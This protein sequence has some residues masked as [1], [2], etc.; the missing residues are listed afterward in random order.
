MWEATEVSGESLHLTYD[1]EAHLDVSLGIPDSSRPGLDQHQMSA[2][3]N[4]QHLLTPCFGSPILHDFEEE[5]S[6]LPSVI[7]NNSLAETW[8]VQRSIADQVSHSACV[9][10]PANDLE[11]RPTRSCMISRSLHTR[12]TSIQGVEE[13]TAKLDRLTFLITNGDYL[14]QLRTNILTLR[15]SASLGFSDENEDVAQILEQLEETKGTYAFKCRL[16]LFCLVRIRDKTA[17]QVK[18]KRVL[19]ILPERGA[20]KV[21]DQ[22]LDILV[23]RLHQAAK[24]DKRSLSLRSWRRQFK[25]ERKKIKNAFLAARIWCTLAE[26]FG[27]GI[28]LLV[29]WSGRSGSLN[30]RW[31]S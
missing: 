5:I 23:E 11:M 28:L 22:V 27:V 29:P 9:T 13:A 12:I 14:R 20:R 19:G 6:I 8:G 4:T 1:R 15:S 10:S 24:R 16:L 21:E 2:L 17:W 3:V 30:H 26:E 25:A 31:V 18:L 7:S